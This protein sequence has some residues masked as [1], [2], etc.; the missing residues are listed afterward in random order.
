M[1]IDIVLIIY[2]FLLRLGKLRQVPSG[3]YGEEPLSPIESQSSSMNM[4]GAGPSSG[5]QP[6]P[7]GNLGLPSQI[8]GVNLA[9]AGMIARM[10]LDYGSKILGSGVVQSS[11]W[12][13][14]LDHLLCTQSHN[15]CI[16]NQQ[17]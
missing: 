7:Y 8:G 11:V 6:N 9:G 2:S 1:Q 5:A 4:G 10:G 14:V 17:C 13:H 12:C 3:P 15:M 16:L